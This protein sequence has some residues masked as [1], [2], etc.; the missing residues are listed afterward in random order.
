MKFHIIAIHSTQRDHICHI[1]GQQFVFQRA[2]VQHLD[3]IHSDAPPLTC[4]E[5]GAKLKNITNLNAHMRRHKQNSED[6]SCTIC[7]KSFPNK[8]AL[9]G[10]V[11]RVHEIWRKDKHKCQFCSKTFYTKADLR[12]HIVKHTGE[13]NF[14][15]QLCPSNFSFSSALYLHR[16]TIHPTEYLEWKQNTGK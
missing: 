16:K 8:S 14:H 5:C 7:K 13:K 15:C 6:N 12:D 4:I 11:R 1:C 3:H 2:L 10:H 9:R